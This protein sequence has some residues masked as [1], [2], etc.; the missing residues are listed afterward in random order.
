MSR[1]YNC[2]NPTHCNRRTLLKLAGASGFSWLT[3]VAEILADQPSLD[4][5]APAKSIIL[6]WLAGGPS[7]LE[8]FDPHP[9]QNIAGGTGAIPT[10]AKGIRLASGLEETAEQM[11]HIA[12]V[13]SV[14]S[15]EG[16]H[17]RAAYN[18]KTGYRPDP[19]LVHPSIGAILCHQ[20]PRGKTEIPRHISILPD[21]W[22]G[23]GGYLGEQYDA[24]RLGDPQQSIPDIRTSISQERFHRRLQNLDVVDH[25]FTQDRMANLEISRTL[26]RKT[27]DQ[28]IRM[29]DSEQLA[30]FDLKDVPSADVAEFG[31]SAFG[32][33]CLVA[34]RLI[35][36]G[37]RCI[38]V[39]LNGWDSHVAN[40][41]LQADR[42]KTLDPAF[43][44]LIR[45]LK[46]RS[47]LDQTMIICG[48][49]FGR[50][51]QINP[52]GGRDHWPHGFSIAFAGGGIEGGQV[53]GET[54]PHGGRIKHEAGIP[55]AD[56]HATVLEAL[57]VKHNL[58]LQTPIGRPLKLTEGTPLAGLCQI[59]RKG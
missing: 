37:V 36:A 50:T 55:I 53:I 2:G 24:F 13:R 6:L 18:V 38:E 14:V 17:E 1:Q 23:R 49:E 32:R 33:G 39:T 12:I 9:N 5:H 45:H 10:S 52:A 57:G 29:M 16:D 42:V 26:H 30:A 19:T 48:G 46:Q 34:G 35:E 56:L 40:H 27:I 4:R 58:E 22:S 31:D 59:P 3:P 41:E 25:Q 20:L 7:Q 21:A 44:A 47:L 28:A 8:T 54:D 51:P 15:R 43:A 11:E